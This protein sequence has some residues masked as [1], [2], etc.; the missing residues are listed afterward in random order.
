LADVLFYRENCSDINA[1]I[2]DAYQPALISVWGLCVT[3]NNP[4]VADHPDMNQK[5]IDSA[6]YLAW[7]CCLG[8]D[9]VSLV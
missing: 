7:L 1:L 8:L 9:Y 2:S 5:V 6:G 3:R 4:T